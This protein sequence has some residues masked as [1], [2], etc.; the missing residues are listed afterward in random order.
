MQSALRSLKLQYHTPRR[1][2]RLESRLTQKKANQMCVDFNYIEFV[3]I[4]KLFFAF[5]SNSLV[6][7]KRSNSLPASVI[8]DLFVL[9]IALR[10]YFACF[11]GL[12][13]RRPNN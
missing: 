11:D 6:A 7:L 4:R 2:P 8:C 1:E 3:C 10:Q 12:L 13:I 9:R 5:D